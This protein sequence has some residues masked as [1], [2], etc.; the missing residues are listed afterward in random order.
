LKGGGTYKDRKTVK[1]RK[2]KKKKKG[3]EGM[4]TMSR[5]RKY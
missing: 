4:T 2:E 1:G 3:R 5:A